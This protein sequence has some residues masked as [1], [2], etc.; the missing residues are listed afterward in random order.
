MTDRAEILRLAVVF[1]WSRRGGSAAA[2][3]VLAVGAAFLTACGLATQAARHVAEAQQARSYAISPQVDYEASDRPSANAL[4][5]IDPWATPARRWNGREIIRRYYARDTSAPRIPGVRGKLLAGDYYASPALV[6][7]VER[8]PTVG[9]LF[10]G[11]SFRGVISSSGLVHPHELSAIIGVTAEPRA[12]LLPVKG[13]GSHQGLGVEEGTF[14]LNATITAMVLAMM[15]LPAAAFVF[16]TSRLCSRQRQRRYRSLRLLGLSTATVR[17]VHGLESILVVVPASLVG[18]LAI[19]LALRHLTK[20]PGT[21]FGFYPGDASIPA[22]AQVLT[23]ALVAV[24]FGCAA[25]LSPTEQPG[26]SG[27]MSAFANGPAGVIGVA[28]LVTGLSYLFTLPFTTTVVPSLAAYGMWAACIAVAAGLALAG[29]RIVG[30]VGTAAAGRARAAGT[31]V[32]IRT[33]TSVAGTTTRLG[34]LASVVIILLLGSLSFMAILNGGGYGN[35]S[36]LLARHEVVPVA[37]SDISGRLTRADMTRIH[38]RGFVQVQSAHS[39]AGELNVVYARCSDLRAISGVAPVDCS[40]E[41]HW[42]NA[43]SPVAGRG[44]TVPLHNSRR[45]PL[46]SADKVTRVGN[47]PSDLDGALLLPPSLAATGPTNEGSLYYVLVENDELSRVL[48]LMSS[49]APG[50]QF[51]LGSLGQSN[52]DFHRFPK[53]LEWLTVGALASLAVAALGL[54]ASLLGEAPERAARMRGLRILGARRTELARA[55]MWSTMLPIT[56]LGWTATG[57]GWQVCRALRAVD[58]RATVPTDAVAWSAV[59][60][61]VVAAVIASLSLP[62]TFRA[63]RE[64]AGFEA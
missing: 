30:A 31:L 14:A 24:S 11:L 34:S 18:C 47:L 5:T 15:W 21:S 33:A 59:G 35:W 41:P 28:G 23:V 20:V 48:A 43:A 42:I 57:L 10:S 12:L 63:T 44:G 58:D 19:N 9:A 7:L 46:P 26:R 8:D 3:A 56:V 1:A 40:S 22:A 38:A 32:G 2:I 37:V 13:F 53:Q 62:D 55:H 4:L 64:S 45:V 25:A 49:R 39:D 52:P 27:P 29:P 50:V 36:E 16:V 54:L 61:V 17:T 51:D 6:D 60:V